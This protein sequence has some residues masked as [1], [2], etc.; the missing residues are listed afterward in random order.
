MNSQID[1]EMEDELQP[2]YDFTQLEG[3]VRGKY[4]DR[5]RAGTN[6]VRL[7]PDVAKSFPNENAVNEALR[8]LIQIAQRQPAN[9]P[10][11]QSD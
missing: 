7:D 6:L 1:T 8:L 2:E 9:N 10:I 3:G 5:Y 11:S 4:V